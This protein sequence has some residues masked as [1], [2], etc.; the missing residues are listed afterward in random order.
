MVRNRRCWVCSDHPRQQERSMVTIPAGT[1]GR[2]ADGAR[3]PRHHRRPSSPPH[4]WVAGATGPRAPMA[5]ATLPQRAR[6]SAA[7][8]AADI[9][10]VGVLRR[11][12]DWR[13]AD[14]ERGGW[15]GALRT[16]RSG[17][18]LFLSAPL[19]VSRISY[20]MQI[21]QQNYKNTWAFPPA[22]RVHARG[23]APPATRPAPAPTRRPS[24][25]ERRR[26]QHVLQPSALSAPLRPPR[27]A[28]RLCGA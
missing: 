13:D 4:P 28:P 22:L 16:T 15:R 17:D 5:A 8:A 3:R 21:I 6:P 14:G 24:L 7:A 10:K 19:S 12:A 11:T 26:G 25:T 9:Q 20:T 18:S 1:G 23:E 27:P 2:A